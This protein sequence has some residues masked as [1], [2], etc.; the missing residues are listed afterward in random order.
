LLN[1]ILE[2]C[3][4]NLQASS[5]AKEVSARIWLLQ[6]A[7][8]IASWRRLSTKTIKNCLLTAVLNTLGDTKVKTTSY[9][10]CNTSKITKGFHASTTVFNVI[11]KTKIVRNKLL[12]NCGEAPG[13][14]DQR[15]RNRFVTTERERMTNQDGTKFIAAL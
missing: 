9:W 14:K 12:K 13:E 7:Q 10:K 1:Y 8:F 5:T 4:E 2:A 11:M 15:T 6:A 3:K